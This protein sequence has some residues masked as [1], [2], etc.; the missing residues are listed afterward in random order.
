MRKKSAKLRGLGHKGA[1]GV[2]TAKKKCKIK[3]IVKKGAKLRGLG[4]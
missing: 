4:H 2:W 1:G 3:R